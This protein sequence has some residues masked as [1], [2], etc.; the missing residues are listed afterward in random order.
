MRWEKKIYRVIKR[1]ALLPITDDEGNCVW[2]E[3]AYISQRRRKW[4]GGE[5]LAWDK[6]FVTKEEYKKYMRE[7]K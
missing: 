6:R 7:R 3:W 5:Y 4:Y 2:L 1:F